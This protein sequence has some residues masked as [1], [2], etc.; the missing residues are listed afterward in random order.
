MSL[1]DNAVRSIQIGL[2]DYQFN[3]RLISSVRN[4]YAGILL[5]FKYKLFLLS[6]KETNAALIKQNVVPAFDSQGVLIWRGVG[7]KTIDVAGIKSRFKS[8][9]IPVEWD[10]F[11]RINKHRNEIE[12]FFS[13]L[14]ENE[15]SELLADCFIIISRFLSNNLNLDAREVLGDE[16]W[17][18]LLHAYEV[19]DYEIEKNAL[20]IKTLAFHH[21]I[22]K[23]IFLDFCCI[24]CSSPLI[25]PTKPGANAEDSF[26]CCAECNYNYS[27]DDICNMGVPDLYINSFWAR[28]E[29]SKH[30]FSNCESC[31]QGLYLKEYCVCTACGPIAI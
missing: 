29:E 14:P 8:L 9:G 13:P 12:H 1:L 30:P 6:G 7:N 2:D 3:D 4:I 11:D 17:Q 26:F 31:N 24:S 19:Y 18:T 16:S 27:Y 23:K 21:S 5:L 20:T 28:F 15:V 22:I 10:A 25:Q